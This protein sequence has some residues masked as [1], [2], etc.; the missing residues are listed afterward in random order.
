MVVFSRMNVSEGLTVWVESA[1]GQRTPVRG[2][3][4]L[5][6]S[7]ACEVVLPNAKA[8]R[9]HALIHGQ[10]ESEFWLIDLGS[11]NGTYL[12]GRRVIQPCR[13]ADQ[14]Q[15][16]IAG[17]TL[18]FKRPTALPRWA[19]DTSITQATVHEVRHLTSW[20][21]IADIQ[22]STK[23]LRELPAE[24]APRIIGR[25]LSSCTK[26]IDEHEGTI[27]KFLGDGFLAYWLA[28]PSVAGS[29]AAALLA[30]RRLQ[31]TASPPF[32]MIL[33]YG[34]VSAGC[35]SP[36]RESLTGHEVNFAFRLEKLAG[37]IGAARL[38]SEAAQREL[39]SELPTVPA[40]RHAVAGFEG[41][42]SF[43][44]F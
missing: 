37:S 16:T 18:T 26:L 33:H 29:V 25:W 24:E 1:S 22:G 6:R 36:S 4:F 28:G 12:N 35:S 43:F 10:E 38:V 41:E 44:A 40:G 23:M 39:K 21:L 7:A 3:C 19:S 15:I 11:A 31:D 30:L 17:Q 9:Q 5:G 34:S 42:F 32:R 20:L 2:S 13:L 14:D 27:D 8:S